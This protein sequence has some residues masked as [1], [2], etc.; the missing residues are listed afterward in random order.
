MTATAA[1]IKFDAPRM[2]AP[3]EQSRAD[4]YALLASLFYRAPD[5]A[6]LQAIVVASPPE[7]SLAESWAALAAAS[8]V[9]TH[10]AVSDEHENLF[11]GVG[12][13]PVMLYGSFYM[14]GFMMEK[15]LAELRET[16]AQLGF[17]RSD[18]VHEPE[19]HLAAVCD[20]MRAL[21]VGDVD[22]KPASIE[23]Q[24]AFF[25]RHMQ[26]WVRKAC[27]EVSAYDSA[28][29]YKRVAAFADA[30]FAL[31]TSAFELYD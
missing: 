13:P 6:L 5:D 7:G 10:D 15:P 14:A 16:L 24:R 19:D 18:A 20:V 30:F 4:F 31:E 23:V 11:I 29:Y 25:S 3:E 17:A 28:N 8:A 26:P 1:A 9:V 12:R 2:V 22:E 27:S 21:I